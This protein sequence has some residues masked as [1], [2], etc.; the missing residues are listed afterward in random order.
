M[1]LAIS[2]LHGA[3]KAGLWLEAGGWVD[4]PAW[5]T[6]AMH[7]MDSAMNEQEHLRMKASNPHG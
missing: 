7:L 6:E 2:E 3:Y 1:T 5:Y 4:Q